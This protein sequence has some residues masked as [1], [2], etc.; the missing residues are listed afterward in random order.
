MAQFFDGID[1]VRF[2]GVD[3]TSPLAYR[4]YD[5]DET[6]LG[7]RLEDQLRF[8]VAWWHSFA[9]EGG[10]PFGSQTFIRPW[11]P[12]DSMANARVKADVAFEMFRILGQPYFCFH[13]ADVRPEAESYAENTDRLK[14]LSVQQEGGEPVTP[15]TDTIRS[16]EYAPLSRPLFIY[17]RNDLVARPEGSAFVKYYLDHAGEM[18]AEV[19]YVAV[20]DEVA[21]EN[22][23]KFEAISE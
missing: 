17:V 21:S 3:S 11:H 9:W 8:A 1:P 16:N 15:S 22:R 2:E 4:H 10:D 5:P 19:G 23:S 12:Q 14:V 6:V 20:S 13:D 7:T 18:A